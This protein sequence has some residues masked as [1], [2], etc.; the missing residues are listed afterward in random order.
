M[1]HYIILCVPWSFLQSALRD[2]KNLSELTSAELDKEGWV[3][4]REGDN[5]KILEDM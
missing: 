1:I 5:K 2:V 3:K 4:K